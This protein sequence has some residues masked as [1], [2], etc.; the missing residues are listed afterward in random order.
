MREREKRRLAEN[1]ITS[2][3]FKTSS[4]KKALILKKKKIRA[5]FGR[6]VINFFITCLNFFMK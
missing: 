3:S 5:I 4:K 6:F 2:L 1:K